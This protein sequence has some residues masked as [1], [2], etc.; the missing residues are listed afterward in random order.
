MKV[1]CCLLI[2]ACLIACGCASV[3]EPSFNTTIVMAKNVEKG[4]GASGITDV[5]THEGII[6]MFATFQWEDVDKPG[7]QQN[8]E[9]KWFNEDRLVMKSGHKFDFTKTPYGRMV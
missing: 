1:L 8:I 9:V 5:F 2:G 7:G 6:F 3:T 4:K